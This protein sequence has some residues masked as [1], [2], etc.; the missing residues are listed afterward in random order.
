[1]AI[2]N[3]H[4]QRKEVLPNAP[5][6]GLNMVSL[7]M[8]VIVKT[9]LEQVELM[10][11]ATLAYVNDISINKDMLSVDEVKS[12]LES[13]GLSSKDPTQLEDEATVLDSKSEWSTTHCSGLPSWLGL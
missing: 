7:I 11:R 9:L 2:P 6:V 4:H 3:S 10:K 13:F 5:G 8:K 12:R 1:M